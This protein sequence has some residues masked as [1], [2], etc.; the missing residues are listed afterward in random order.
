MNK[1]INEELDLQ[2]HVNFL[3]ICGETFVASDELQTVSTP[4][5]PENHPPNQDCYW[6]LK[7]DGGKPIETFLNA[8]KMK[9][10]EDF[11]EVKFY[12]IT[13]FIRTI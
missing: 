11:V 1:K 10:E 9:S 3:V 7:S 6:I 5:W 8:G 12:P 4:N 13:L 2:S